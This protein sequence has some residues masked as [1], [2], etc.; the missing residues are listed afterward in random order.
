MFPIDLC[1][2]LTCTWSGPR[3]ASSITQSQRGHNIYFL[4]KC[5][6]HT[7]CSLV[8][9]SLE[10]KTLKYFEHHHKHNTTDLHNSSTNFTY[11]GMHISIVLSLNWLLDRYIASHMR[12]PITNTVLFRIMPC[13]LDIQRKLLKWSDILVC[14][15]VGYKNNNNK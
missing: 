1:L 3:S 2:Q 12:Y 14:F 15:N 5:Q 10:K 9:T 8:Q 4:H 7:V 13:I 6:L 11:I